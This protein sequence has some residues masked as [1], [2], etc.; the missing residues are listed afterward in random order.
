MQRKLIV[1]VIATAAIGSATGSA[2]A[3]ATCTNAQFGTAGADRAI[4]TVS[5][6]VYDGLGGDDE[7]YGRGG[8]DCLRGSD[9]NDII[10]G[11]DGNDDLTGGSGTDTLSGGS[12]DDV[13]SAF[14]GTRDYV[15]CG[16][17]TDTAYV[18]QADV[19]SSSCERV[20]KTA[21]PT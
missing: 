17:G 5:A 9:G 1:A 8:D 10:S 21:R 3:A 2:Q 7:I 11:G 15:S 12:G 14:D 13:I 18:D 4:L 19:V 20:I 6:D 16:S